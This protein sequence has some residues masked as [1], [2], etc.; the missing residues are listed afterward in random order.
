MD[1]ARIE[2]II[3]ATAAKHDHTFHSPTEFANVLDMLV[4]LHVIEMT[5][6]EDGDPVVGLTEFG[7]RVAE[8]L[9]EGEKP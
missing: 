6:D 9:K 2:A 1:L 7:K 8:K 5:E 4:K 3:A